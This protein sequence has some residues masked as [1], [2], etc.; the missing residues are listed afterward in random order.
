[1]IA[2]LRL[3]PR[4]L[5]LVLASAATPVFADPFTVEHLLQNESFGAVRI[6][7]DE[8]RI[9]FERQGPYAAIDRFDLGYFGRWTTSEVWVVDRSDPANPRA[10]LGEAVRRG[11]VMGEFSPNGRR[12]VVHR[13]QNDR[14]ETG[15]VELASGSVQW[16][17]L[18]A[19]PPIKG[20]TTL[21]R[22]DD[23]LV[24]VARI[25]ADLPY[26][27]GAL[28]TGA[29]HS[30]E[31][32]AEAARGG[33]ATTTWGAGAFAAPLGTAARLGTWSIDLS[34][35]E[36]R[37]L[38]EGQTLD[39][40]LSAS[41]RWLAIV[42]RGA[43]E[44][45]DPNRPLRPSDQAEARRLTLMDLDTDAIW[46]PCGEC[47][48]AS[49]LLGWSADDRLLVW[50]RARSDQA[51]AGALLSI[52][53]GRREVAPLDLGGV[54]PDVGQT[55]DS[56]F[57]TVRAAWIGEDAIILGRA[58]GGSRPDWHRVGEA[59]MNLTRDLPSAPGG[60][61][62]VSTDHFLTFADGALWSIGRNGQALRAP[63]PERL[64]A[65]TTLTHWASPRRRLNSPPSRDWTLGRA[66]DGSLWRV[67]AAGLV[68]KIAAGASTTLRA[69]GGHVA[70]DG[71]VGNGVETLRLLQPEAAPTPLARVNEAYARVEFAKPMPVL[72]PGAPE[73]FEQSWL[74]GPAGGLVAGTPV[75][76]IAY[77]G[78]NVRPGANPAEFY[79]M[80]N[81][82]LLVSL[83]YAVLTP[84]LPPTGA[85]GPAAHLTDRIMATLDAALAQYPEL[86]GDR[87]GYIGH[88]FGGYTGLVLASETRRIRSYVIMSTTANLAAGWGGF[89]SF[90]RQNPE[91]GHTM[92][93]RNAGWSEA[94][95]GGIGGPPWRNPEAYADNSPLFR[96]DRIDAPVL[97]IHGEFD[98]VGINEAE[99]MFTALWRQNK[100]AQLVTYWG[101]QH[102]FY[103]PGTVR[104]LWTRIDGWFAR[105]IG[106]PPSRLTSPAFG[107]PTDESRPRE[108]PPQESPRRLPASEGHPPPGALP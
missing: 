96:A 50:E 69:A 79:T 100:D 22:T 58:V 98:F 31:W 106:C 74:Y 56:R 3:L 83:G 27:I 99:A 85:D 65:V 87:V 24:L 67:N 66:A 7:P 44:P 101:E 102:L 72:T 8:R 2:R 78:A 75:I 82:E 26:E 104:D 77:P 55:R 70:I 62:G 23:E 30:R 12:L 95:Q 34:S 10:L 46:R 108:T 11:V 39:V 73:G 33:V 37:L 29:L 49:G 105:T 28:A 19:E 14:W 61:E 25:D 36:R 89:G 71:V 21:W 51:A 84:A 20:E 41:G 18:G 16:L 15:V 47:D 90:L 38:H 93:R 43:P 94:G 53:P 35:G 103:S 54:E 45:V 13:L 9:F 17:G 68:Q 40:A 86:D 42:E 80:T 76:I 48:I 91:F 5:A 92:L 107:F 60:L 4:M 59:P 63:T 32:R 88:S 97:L 52:T 6:S 1:M 57:L 64:A 81:V